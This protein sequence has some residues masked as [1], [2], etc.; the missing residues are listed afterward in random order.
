M[1]VII[2]LFFIF[3]SPEAKGESVTVYKSPTCGCCVKYVAELKRNGFDVNVVTT[4]NMKQ[5]KDQHNIPSNMESCHTAV[6][7]DY[8][9]EGHVPL[10]VVFSLLRE[11]PNITGIALPGMPSGT[12]GMPGPKREPYRISQ[13]DKNEWSN[14]LTI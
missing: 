7:E 4:N 14:Y 3:D 6:F 1:V 9:V 2:I 11:R 8:F 5:I 12:P 13:L 10:D